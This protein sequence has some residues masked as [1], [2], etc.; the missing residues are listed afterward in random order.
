[1][2]KTTENTDKKQNDKPWLWKKGQ[3]GNPNG[4]PKGT[5]HA[6]T[7]FRNII[8]KKLETDPDL[9]DS[10]AEYY[11]HN[12]KMKELLWK[13]IDG[14]PQGSVPPIDNRTINITQINMELVKEQAYR[15][16]AEDMGIEVKKL[17]SLG[18]EAITT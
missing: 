10:I 5:I 14:M 16:V 12:P 3:S 17:K 2:E 4:K 9:A 8:I 18:G 7:N 15:L 1:M 6:F 13:M 11:L